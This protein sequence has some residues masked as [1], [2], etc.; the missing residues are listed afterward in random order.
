MVTM[1][2]VQYAEWT[3]FYNV[4]KAKFGVRNGEN[5]HMCCEYLHLNF[6]ICFLSVLIARIAILVKNNF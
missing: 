1:A 5:G 4:P 2:T 3:V 6:S